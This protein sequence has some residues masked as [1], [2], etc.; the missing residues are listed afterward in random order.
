[1]ARDCQYVTSRPI[2]E[3]YLKEQYDDGDEKLEIVKDLDK[4]GNHCL[5]WI[6]YT[7]KNQKI[8]C[9][10]YNKFVQM[11]ES[12]E[13]RMSLGSRMEDLVMAQDKKLHK[14]L[15]KAKKCGLSRLEITFYGKKL[16]K[17]A[18]YEEVV[19]DT[20]DVLQDC[21]TYRVPFEEYWRYMAS[22]ITSMV[23]VHIVAENTTA[24]AYCHWWNSITKKKYG[25]YRN[26]VGKDEAMKALANYSF[27]DRPIYLLEVEMENGIIK[28]IINTKYKR[29]IG[30]TEITLVSGGHDD[31]K[32][33][34][35]P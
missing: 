5:S 17:F 21:P 8:R 1:I 25:S 22:T 15:R 13:T 16:R 34:T 27:N 2:L 32:I 10:M 20:M 14:R 3:K 30:C 4:V 11:M 12:A 24:F 31:G 7:Y 28:N 33:Y 29:P 23:G 18:Y 19:N 9:K 26:K 6:L 35:D